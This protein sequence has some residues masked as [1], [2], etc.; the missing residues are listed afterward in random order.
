MQLFNV[1]YVSGNA[2]DL[3]LSVSHTFWGPVLGQSQAVPELDQ[4]RE[5]DAGTQVGSSQVGRGSWQVS[6]VNRLGNKTY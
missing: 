3:C 1:Y 6:Q 4:G 5:P 2:L